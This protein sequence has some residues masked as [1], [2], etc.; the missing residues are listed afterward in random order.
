MKWINCDGGFKSIMDKLAD[1]LDIPTNYAN[2]DDH[3][4]DIEGNNQVVEEIFRISCYSLPYKKITRLMIWYLAMIDT[5]KW[6]IFLAKG[7]I[8]AYYYPCMILN[9][10]NWYYKKHCRYEFGSYVQESQVNKPTN[11]NLARTV[12]AIYLSPIFKGNTN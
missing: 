10:R 2:P 6:N 8:S 3:V 9:Q 11:M 12:D 7:G 5:T 4:T 1:S